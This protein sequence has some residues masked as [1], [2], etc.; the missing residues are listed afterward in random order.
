MIGKS[1]DGTLA[2]AAAASG[3][4]GLSTIVPISA[5]SSWYLYSRS[6]GIRFNTNYAASLASTVTNPD[7]RAYCAPVREQLSLTDDDESADYTPYW[8]ERN[9]LPAADQVTASVFV[10]HGINDWNVKTDHLVQWWDALGDNGVTRK[11]WLTGTGHV[12]PFDFR[13][14]EWVSTLHRWF[15][16]ELMGIDNGIHD[17]PMVDIE[18]APDVWETHATWP[19]R[20]RDPG[21]A[22]PVPRRRG[23]ARARSGCA[24]R[25]PAD[26]TFVDRP[27]TS[28]TQAITTPE[29]PGPN[30]LV[31][32]SEPLAVPLHVSGSPLVTLQ[33]SVDGVDTNFAAVLVDYGTPH[34]V[35]HRGRRGPHPRRGDR[36][37]L[38]P[39]QRRPTTPATGRPRRRWRPCRRRW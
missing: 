18:R 35:R 8:Y 6:N 38:G 26:R 24:P 25:A 15:D 9:Y 3:V 32:L 22:V 12:D 7:R 36:G 30:R 23:R 29:V 17:E 16:A 1:Y 19:L 10:V 21:P 28:R 4:E 20:R 13:R 37:L 33:A 31:H 14:A 5:I 2:N 27:T 11:L 34:A 39:G